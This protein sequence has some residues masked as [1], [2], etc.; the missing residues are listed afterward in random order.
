MK[1]NIFI[2]IFTLRIEIRPAVCDY[3]YLLLTFNRRKDLKASS[4]KQKK[5]LAT[6]DCDG[7]GVGDAP[8]RSL[9][10]TWLASGP[11]SGGQAGQRGR[12]RVN[13][14]RWELAHCRSRW[15][16]RN[17]NH[18]SV[19]TVSSVTCCWSLG[20]CESVWWEAVTQALF[21]PFSHLALAAK[22]LWFDY[23]AGTWLTKPRLPPSSLSFLFF[24]SLLC[25]RMYVCISDLSTDGSEDI[26][27]TTLS[28]ILNG[29]S[30]MWSYFTTVICRLV[31]GFSDVRSY[32]KC[33]QT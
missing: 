1:R 21:P 28:F 18:V 22:L 32:Y 29:M 16:S 9:T 5:T 19:V 2:N 14:Y 31:T 7:V 13:V 12:R 30:S 11:P 24:L 15:T 17:T 4:W 20:Y 26:W 8:P 27:D 3:S 10:P 33:F 6:T 25:G 23:A